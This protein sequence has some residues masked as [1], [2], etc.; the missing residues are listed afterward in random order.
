MFWDIVKFFATITAL[1]GVLSLLKA[2]RKKYFSA[3]SMN[4]LLDSA[5]E[6][7]TEKAEQIGSYI[8]A[9]YRN[10]KVKKEREKEKPYVII[11]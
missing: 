5:G 11:R 3:E 10:Y 2:F 9:K 4:R 7:S 6:K 8:N 1:V